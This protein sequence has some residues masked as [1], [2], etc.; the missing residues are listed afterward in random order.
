MRDNVSFVTG[1]GFALVMI[2]LLVGWP[3][4]EFLA[5]KRMQRDAVKAGVAEYRADSEGN[6]EFRWKAVKPERGE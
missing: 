6:V 3:I 4:G 2:G 5:E 1:C